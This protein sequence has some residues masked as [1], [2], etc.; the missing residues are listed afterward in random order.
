[1]IDSHADFE[2]IIV[3]SFFLPVGQKCIYA[4]VIQK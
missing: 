4:V 3:Y 2:I 1:M